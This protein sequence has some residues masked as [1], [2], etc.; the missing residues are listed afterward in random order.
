M[1]EGLFIVSTLGKGILGDLIT[2]N[3]IGGNY[4]NEET[5]ISQLISYKS[6]ETRKKHIIDFYERN[7]DSRVVFENYIRHLNFVFRNHNSN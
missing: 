3:N 1:S 6:N 7:F 5:L 2:K 4:N